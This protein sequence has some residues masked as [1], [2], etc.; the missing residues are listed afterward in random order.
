MGLEEVKSSLDKNLQLTDEVR[1]NFYSL[2]NIL[3]KMYPTFDLSNLCRCLETVEIKKVSKFLNRRVSKYDFEKNIIELNVEKMNEGYDMKH[4]MMSNVLHM[5]TNNGKFV[6]FNENNS[7]R[8]LNEGYTEMVSNLLVGNDS[9]I[10]YLKE[11]YSS[12]DHVARVVGV[13][14]MTKAY[15]NNEPNILKL[16]MNNWNMTDEYNEK[17][18]AIYDQ[19][20][21]ELKAQAYQRL[22]PTSDIL[23]VAPNTVIDDIKLNAS[24]NDPSIL[25]PNLEALKK[26]VVQKIDELKKAKTL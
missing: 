17:L 20:N 14:I 22:H 10:G 8:A 2:A 25:D 21:E 18:N 6:G 15:F 5:A 1:D 24:C 11:E 4:V 19:E 12:A 3:N 7:F 16:A 9:D 13:D 26:E 23:K